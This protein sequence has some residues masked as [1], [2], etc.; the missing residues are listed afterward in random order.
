MSELKKPFFRSRNDFDKSL[1][2]SLMGQIAKKHSDNLV[3]FLAGGAKSVKNFA[4]RHATK[5]LLI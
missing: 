3:D 5:T 2:D 1:S 4:G